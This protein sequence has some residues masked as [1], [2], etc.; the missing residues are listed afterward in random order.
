MLIESG[1]FTEASLRQLIAIE[2][3]AKRTEAD[4]ASGRQPAA[5]TQPAADARRALPR[6]DIRTVA[7]AAPAVAPM[8][9]EVS[10]YA[11]LSSAFLAGKGVPEDQQRT[12]FQAEL[13]PIILK[14][15]I[16][17]TYPKLNAAAVWQGLKPDARHQIIIR[18]QGMF[19]AKAKAA[20]ERTEARSP[21]APSR[22]QRPLHQRD[23]RNGAGPRRTDTKPADPVE[24]ILDQLTGQG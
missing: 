2:R 24:S 4:K 5:R 3:A 10:K 19:E 23:V 14:D 20:N 12:H 22:V 18:A 16:A 13:H 6:A 17:K 8:N 9:P 7:R 15:I 1:D 21:T 11:K